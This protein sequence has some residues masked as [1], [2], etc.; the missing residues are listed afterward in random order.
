M[1]AGIGLKMKKD[2]SVKQLGCFKE[3]LRK[4]G[5]VAE[6]DPM[7]FGYIRVAVDDQDFAGNH[8]QLSLGALRVLELM[9]PVENERTNF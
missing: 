1:I 8:L 9:L 3:L 7:V 4:I 2:V 5:L 6:V